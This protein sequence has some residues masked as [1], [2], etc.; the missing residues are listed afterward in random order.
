M[1]RGDMPA[2]ALLRRA[3]ACLPVQS[4]DRLRILPDLAEALMELPE[5]DEA[6]ACFGRPRPAP[7]PQGDEDLAA[8]AELV[9]LLVQ[10]YSS[11]EGGWSDNALRVGRPRDPVF[12]AE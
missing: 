1:T 10:Q 3:A 2:S 11:E 8:T 12:E 5:F 7:M 9:E 4:L 6:D